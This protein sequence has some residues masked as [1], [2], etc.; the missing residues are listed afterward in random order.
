M[1]NILRENDLSAFEKYRLKSVT[2][3]SFNVA[4][5]MDKAF[6][7][8]FMRNLASSIGAPTERTAA[9]IFIKRYAFIAVISLFAMTTG[10]KK[11]NLSLDNIEMEEAKRGID[12]LPMISL[13]NPSIEEWNGQDRDEWRKGVY[14]DLFANNI[15]PIIEHFEKTFK[16]SKLILW[17]NIAVYLFWLYETELSDNE[18][19][20]VAS[21]FYFL[22]KEAEGKLFGK[23]NLN[24]IHKYY[25]EKA[26]QVEIRMRKT[27]CFTY[28][29]GTK[30][31]KT[32]PCTRNA[33]DGVCYDGESFCG[34]ASRLDN[35]NDIQQNEY[36]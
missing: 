35:I 10:N 29:L 16:V 12:W 32:C 9:S 4:N 33:E 14:R 15:Y 19:P 22:I 34:V 11:M 8:D 31:C 30:R 20:N 5:L 17:E 18:N 24:P 6:A 1:G 13:K 3:K 2:G 7:I 26:S 36:L 25:S 28:Q 23:Y 21:D 27:C